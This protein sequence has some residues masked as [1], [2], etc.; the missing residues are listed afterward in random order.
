MRM[1]SSIAKHLAYIDSVVIDF[2][3]NKVI[4]H[5]AAVGILYGCRVKTTS[6]HLPRDKFW[7]LVSGC[8]ILCLEM[9]ETSVLGLRQDLSLITYVGGAMTTSTYVS[10]IKSSISLRTNFKSPES[11]DQKLRFFYIALLPFYGCSRAISTRWLSLFRTLRILPFLTLREGYVFEKMLVCV[12]T[13][14][15]TRSRISAG[16]TTSDQIDAENMKD[17]KTNL[18][19]IVDLISNMRKSVT[20]ITRDY[21]NLAAKAVSEL[22]KN[23]ESKRVPPFCLSPRTSYILTPRSVCAFSFLPLSHHSSKMEIFRFSDLCDYL[24]NLTFIRRNLKFIL[25]YEPSINHHKAYGFS[26]K[27]S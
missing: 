20:I 13:E 4:R 23:S 8:L 19:K 11:A 2:D 27:K 24:R 22:P 17:N 3:P 10:L 9:L 16:P 7:D 25:S 6:S 5:V 18:E 21:K 12:G 15:R 1:S 14:I 26:V